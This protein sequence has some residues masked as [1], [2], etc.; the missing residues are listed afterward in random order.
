MKIKGVILDNDQNAVTHIKTFIDLFEDIEILEIFDNAIKASQ[1]LST[2][3]ID[4]IFVDINLS[5]VNGISFIKNI[6]PNTNIIVTTKLKELA[7]DC[8]EYGVLDFLV[9]PITIE[10]FLK[11]INRL[12]KQVAFQRKTNQNDSAPYLFIKELKRFIKININDILFIESQKDYIKITLVEK[13]YLTLG[14][15]STFCEELPEDFIR[16]HRSFCISKKYVDAVNGNIIELKGNKIPIGRNY[17]KTVK[18]QLL[19][20]TFQN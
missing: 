20:N 11:S 13:S 16:V 19:S 6:S 18:S 2:R 14:S 10:R 9:K 4:V 7:I 1:F 8:F 3:E 12:Q 5:Q 15:L 17:I